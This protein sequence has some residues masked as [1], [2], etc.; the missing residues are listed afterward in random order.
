[1]QTQDANR[2]LSVRLL[3][4]PCARPQLAGNSSRGAAGSLFSVY[5]V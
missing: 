2:P 5:F 4:V 3:W 1:M